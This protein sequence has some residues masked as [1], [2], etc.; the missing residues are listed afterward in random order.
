VFVF[1]LALA[2]GCAPK[3]VA[4][5][6]GRATTTFE[7]ACPPVT[8]TGPS[9]DPSWHREA[10]YSAYLSDREDYYKTARKSDYNEFLYDDEQSDEGLADEPQS[11]D[12]AACSGNLEDV[13]TVPDISEIVMSEYQD[14]QGV[15]YRI[16]GSDTRGIDCSGLVQAIFR[17]AFE[18]ELPRTSGEQAKLGEAV[19]RN[20]IKPG[21]LVYFIDR[22]RKHVGVAINDQ[23]FV[24]AS[25][26]KGVIISKFDGYWSSRLQRVRR[27]L[28]EK[29]REQI[30]HR[31]G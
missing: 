22:G 14:W 13:P 7:A 25:R 12:S 29:E 8:A 11:E 27:I 31:G 6:P 4:P 23:K 2:S 21:D 15:R 20:D 28:D 3:A 24:H 26:R 9:G 19:P 17:E 10:V 30:I 18:I 5:V 16:G 1:F